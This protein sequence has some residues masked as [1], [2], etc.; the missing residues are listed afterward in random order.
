[1]H[2]A[3]QTDSKCKMFIRMSWVTSMGF[4][5]FNLDL[6]KNHL[7]RSQNNNSIFAFKC[8]NECSID[9][10]SHSQTWVAIFEKKGFYFQ[11]C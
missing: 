1:M 2:K 4:F 7:T 6:L 9:K 3:E 5:F 10:A 11:A 8:K